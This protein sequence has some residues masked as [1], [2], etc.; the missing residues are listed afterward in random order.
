MVPPVPVSEIAVPAEVAPTTLA[1][2][3]GTLGPLVAES[4]TATVATTPLPITLLF[5]PLA[6]HIV[7]PLPLLQRIVLPAAVRAAPAVTFTEVTSLEAYRNVHCK[8]AG[9]FPEEPLKERFKLSE[10]P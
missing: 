10:P 7:D 5:M 1:V 2:D 8:A 4:L 9:P 6:R 3:T